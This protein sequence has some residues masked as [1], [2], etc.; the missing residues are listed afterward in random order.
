MRRAGRVVS[1]TAIVEAVWGLENDIED[2]TL[3]A[4]VRLLR[5]KVD[6]GF[7]SKLI[8]TVRGIGYCLRE[9]PKA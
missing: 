4:F 6:H 5:R 8:E 7:N 3:D 9:G 2:N 1:R